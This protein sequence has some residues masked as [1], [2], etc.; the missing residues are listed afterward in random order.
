MTTSLASRLRGLRCRQELIL[1]V[2]L[3]MAEVVRT[4]T[5]L[6]A[7]EFL[8][9]SKLQS[10]VTNHNTATVLILLEHVVALS[11]VVISSGLNSLMHVIQGDVR[12]VFI[13]TVAVGWNSRAPWRYPAAMNSNLSRCL[14]WLSVVVPLS[15]DESFSSLVEVYDFLHCGC[16]WIDNVTRNRFIL[17][18]ECNV[19]PDPQ[20]THRT[21]L[22]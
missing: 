16:I 3:L 12:V 15:W 10:V 2:L 14:N 13:A 22:T 17:C 1:G 9:L 20:K 5:Q 18:I 19:L 7:H 21:L 11:M 8:S 4:V 6:L